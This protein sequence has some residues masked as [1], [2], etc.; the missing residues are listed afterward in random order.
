MRANTGRSR[1]GRRDEAA[2]AAGAK[3]VSIGDRRC[4]LGVS[5]IRSGVWAPTVSIDPS[6]PGEQRQLLTSSPDQT[7][8]TAAEAM[9]E[10]ERMAERFINPASHDPVITQA[11]AML[12]NSNGRRA[13]S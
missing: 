9:L 4:T 5:C 12:G 2:P 6:A 11:M 7:R 13:S 10:A 3:T 8:T 1:R